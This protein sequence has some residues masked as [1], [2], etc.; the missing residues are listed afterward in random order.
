MLASPLEP[1]GSI[2]GHVVATACDGCSVTV[3]AGLSRR[4]ALHEVSRLSE[5]SFSAC[6]QRAVHIVGRELAGLF[7]EH[8]KQHCLYPACREIA[9]LFEEHAKRY[10]RFEGRSSTRDG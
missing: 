1:A 3:L 5:L 6:R 10:A 9:G 8:A 4:G 2:R 7:E